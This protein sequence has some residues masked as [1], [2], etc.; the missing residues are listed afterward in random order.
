M[1]WDNSNFLGRNMLIEIQWHVQIDS[2]TLH[3]L[4]TLQDALF[5]IMLNLAAFLQAS[6]S[7]RQSC[8]FTIQRLSLHCTLTSSLSKMPQITAWLMRSKSITRRLVQH[9]SELDVWEYFGSCQGYSTDMMYTTACYP[10]YIFLMQFIHCLLHWQGG[11]AC[12][13]SKTELQLDW[14]AVSQGPIV[15][16]SVLQYSEQ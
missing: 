15:L 8:I 16:D 11:E 13:N 9:G 4:K 14:Q 6:F 10:K 12:S 5:P 7:V 3:C 1:H 2:W